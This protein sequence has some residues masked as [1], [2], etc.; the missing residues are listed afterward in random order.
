MRL[1]LCV[2][3][4]SG[5]P[6]ATTSP[7]DAPASGPL[8]VA[9][10][11]TIDVTSVSVD[12]LGLNHSGYAE[13]KAL[14]DDVGALLLNGVRPPDK[15]LPSLLRIDTAAGTFWRYPPATP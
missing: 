2:A 9:G 15:R 1:T 5:V 8:I 10:V 6:D 3:I 11:D 7:P 12:G 4:S 13:N 14:L